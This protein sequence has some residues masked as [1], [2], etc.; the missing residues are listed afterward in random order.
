M[1]D[2][3]VRLLTERLEVRILPPE[4]KTRR[5][6]KMS[7]KYSWASENQSASHLT[8]LLTTDP[9][10]LKNISATPRDLHFAMEELSKARAMLSKTILSEP[11]N[12]TGA[13]WGRWDKIL[14][15]HHKIV[16]DMEIGVQIILEKLKDTYL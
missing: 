13:D 16:L 1:V 2:K 4:P 15:E 12:S 7:K 9:E 6:N 8:G 11:E 3:S 10:R 14:N 5:E